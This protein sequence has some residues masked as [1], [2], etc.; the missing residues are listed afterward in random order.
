MLWVLLGGLLLGSCVK[1]DNLIKYNAADSYVYF[2]YPDADNEAAER[3]TDSINYSF[4]LDPEM[5]ASSK[6]LKI[7]LQITGIAS[8][9]NRAVAI[10]VAPESDYLASTVKIST[11]QIGAN[12]IGDTLYVTLNREKE[13]LEKEMT[14]VLELQGNEAFK[15][16]NAYNKKIKIL[17]SNILTRPSWWTTW[18]LYFGDF[19]KEK[20]HQ[21]MLIYKEGLDPTPEIYGNF[22]GPYYYWNRM[23]IMNNS[24]YFPVTHMYVQVLKKYF[25]DHIVYPDGDSSQDRILLP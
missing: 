21:W 20:L 11:A 19:H 4:A 25:E 7:P 16:G 9:A 12:S 13:L 10:A 22:P 17:Y 2:A 24:D 23:P 14:L 8:S 1:D 5:T 15:V 18:E 6:I 3:F